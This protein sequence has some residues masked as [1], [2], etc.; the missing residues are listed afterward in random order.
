MVLSFLIPGLGQPRDEMMPYPPHPE[1]KVPKSWL[2]NRITAD[3]SSK[4]IK[5]KM[6]PDDEIWKFQFLAP[7]ASRSGVAIVRCGVVVHAELYMVS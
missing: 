2:W 3:K 6:Q 7:L 1:D 4:S 5:A